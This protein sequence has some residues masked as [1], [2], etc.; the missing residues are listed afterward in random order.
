M[1]CLV[2]SMEGGSGQNGIIIYTALHRL[3]K[4]TAHERVS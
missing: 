3:S 4:G 1:E 2:F